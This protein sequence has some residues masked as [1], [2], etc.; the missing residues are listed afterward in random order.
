VWEFPH[1]LWKGHAL[2][3]QLN[4]P[5]AACKKNKKRCGNR[6]KVATLWINGAYTQHAHL[7]VAVSGRVVISLRL[8]FS[9]IFSLTASSPSFSFFPHFIHATLARDCALLLALTYF[10][11]FS[12]H[13]FVDFWDLPHFVCTADKLK[14]QTNLSHSFTLSPPLSLPFS[15]CLFAW[16]PVFPINYFVIKWI[17]VQSRQ[18]EMRGKRY[19]NVAMTFQMM[20]IICSS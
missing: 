18:S 9:S 20:T 6:I 2:H 13:L 17:R 11:E 3:T 14:S 12:F 4:A 10:I 1:L 15:I 7:E 16:S 8:K 5:Y 19:G